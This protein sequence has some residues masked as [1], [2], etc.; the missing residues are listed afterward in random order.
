MA[1]SRKSGLGLVDQ[2]LS[3]ATNFLTAF[4]ASYI[5]APDAFSTFVVGYAIVTVV[6]AVARAL[7]GEPLLAHLPT[8]AG[9]ARAS[10]ISSAMGCAL[11]AGG[12]A[13][14]LLLGLWL[15]G[16]QPFTSLV[17]FAPWLPVVLVQDACRFVF[18]ARED[19]GRALTLDVTWA[20]AQG[21]VLVVT[22]VLGH[23]SIAT[24]SAGWGIGALASIAAF[25]ILT[26]G[27]IVPSDPRPWTR[28]TR[29][30]S[31][32]F[33]L[34][35]LLGQCEIYAVLVLAGL[36]LQPIDT[37]GLRAVQLLV[38]QPS[39]TL[40]AALLF[41]LTP[42]VARLEADGRFREIRIVRRIALGGSAV[43][44]AGILLVV[45][46]HGFLLKNFFPLY[47]AFGGLVLP[48][49]LQSIAYAFSSP[50]VALL[51]G[52][53]RARSLFLVQI[54][55]S[56]L[57][58][59]AALVGMSVAGVVGLAWGLAASSAVTLIVLS[60]AAPRLRGREDSER[61]TSNCRAAQF[62]D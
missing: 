4:L 6:L 40:M 37:A 56:P 11:V 18:L 8:V 5:L 15:S 21:V 33:T 45:P 10:M 43:L 32:W 23:L 44:S 13:S 54:L 17:W 19:T 27:M 25:L 30:L 36:V 53:R 38:F 34:I 51:R 29:Y 31:G 39:I 41:V 35:S 49:A 1:R 61:R 12:A 50:F 47:T 57:L 9:R 28:E 60:S 16:A 46:L 20:G 22:I 55:S 52:F 59:V 7:V 26:R 58:I 24:L 2:I 3:S 14:I 62:H 48:L 42:V